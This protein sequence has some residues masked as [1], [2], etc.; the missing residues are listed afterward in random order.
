MVTYLYICICLYM[1]VISIL[2]LLHPLITWL[3]DT[4][5][6]YNVGSLVPAC[7]IHVGV[8]HI[9][10]SRNGLVLC[11]GEWWT[12]LLIGFVSSQSGTKPVMVD[13]Y[14]YQPLV[15]F[16]FFFVTKV[17]SFFR[18]FI[19]DFE[20]LSPISQPKNMLLRDMCWTYWYMYPLD[21]VLRP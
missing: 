19:A 9:R 6:L 4:V 21:K 11:T 10:S 3:D 2:G 13:F 18:V 5:S 12:C 14:C 1:V 7:Y 8:W 20:W 15:T 16:D 17:S